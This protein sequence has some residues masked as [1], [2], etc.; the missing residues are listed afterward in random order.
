M[1]SRLS[2]WN[3]NAVFDLL[4]EFSV[5]YGNRKRTASNETVPLCGIVENYRTFAED[6]RRVSDFV[7]WLEDG[8]Y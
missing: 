3:R 4:D 1:K 2:N 8:E 5:G 7:E 6:F